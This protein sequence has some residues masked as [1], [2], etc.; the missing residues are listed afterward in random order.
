MCFFYYCSAFNLPK[1]KSTAWIWDYFE[2]VRIMSCYYLGCPTAA[3]PRARS[4]PCASCPWCCAAARDSPRLIASCGCQQIF[5]AKQEYF[6]KQINTFSICNLSNASLAQCNAINGE[7]V[8]SGTNYECNLSQ[9][10]TLFQCNIL[11]DFQ[12]IVKIFVGQ[13]PTQ[14]E[15]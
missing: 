2:W 12:V 11:Q 10:F 13:L 6:W 4:P 9:Y 5:F 7:V 3:G 14:E 15:S 8:R 1:L